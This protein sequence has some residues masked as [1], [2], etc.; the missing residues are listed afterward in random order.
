MSWGNF[1]LGSSSVLR[2]LSHEERLSKMSRSCPF[3]RGMR[4]DLFELNKLS[5]RLT[6]MEMILLNDGKRSRRKGVFKS[7]V[8][9]QN[10][11]F[12]RM[13]NA[14]SVEHSKPIDFWTT[15]N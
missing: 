13:V 6:V 7:F 8:N 4:S 12:Q 9:L 14:V 5:E 1:S 10:S 2:W 3:I 11:L 15:Q